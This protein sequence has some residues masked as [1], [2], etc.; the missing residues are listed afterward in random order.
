MTDQTPESF[1]TASDFE[2]LAESLK[3]EIGFE[4]IVARFLSRW[5]HL[6]FAQTAIVKADLA[7]IREDGFQEARGPLLAT[8][9]ARA[10]VREADRIEAALASRAHSRDELVALGGQVASLPSGR[11]QQI[12]AAIK[13]QTEQRDAEEEAQ[14]NPGTSLTERILKERGNQSTQDGPDPSPQIK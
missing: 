6:E 14:A 5:P 9:F 10:Q 2:D 11:R 3:S 13:K 4:T 7:W 8:A 1:P 12:Q